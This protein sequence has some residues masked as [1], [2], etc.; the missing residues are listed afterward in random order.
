MSAAAQYKRLL[1]KVAQSNSPEDVKAVYDFCMAKHAGLGDNLLWAGIGALPAYAIG[2]S[3][4]EDAEK[5][6]HRNYALAGAAAG[7]LGPKLISAL[8]NPS[9]AFPST[10]GFDASDIKDLQLESID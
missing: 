9:E 8:I 2:K 5:K 6:K 7:F 1:E 3:V 4:A 10:A